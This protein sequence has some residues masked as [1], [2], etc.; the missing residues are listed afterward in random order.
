MKKKSQSGAIAIMVTLILLIILST[1]LLFLPE[2]KPKKKNPVPVATVTPTGAITPIPAETETLAV[3]LEV[4]T[5]VK[6]ITVYDVEAE[7]TKRLVYTG[8]TSFYDGYGIQLSAGQL[9]KGDMYR[10]YINVKEEWISNAYEAVDRR[11]KPQNTKVWEKTGVDYMTVSQG[12]ISFRGQNYRYNDGICV[13][14]NGRQITLGDIQPTVDI[15]T[16]RGVGQVIYEIDVTKGHGYITLKNHEDFIGGVIT[17]GSTRVDSVYEDATYLVREGTYTVSVECGKYAG[18]EDISVVRDATAVFDVF[19]YGSG[20]IKKGWL[21]I[22]ID[23]LGADLYID[24]V[25][26]AYTD[27]VELEYG[28]YRFEFSEGGYT[29]YNATVLIDQPK[30]SLSVFLIEQKPEET[31]PDDDD[32]TTTDPN[33]PD[34]GDDT[35]T[36]PEDPDNNTGE[37]NGDGAGENSDNTGEQTGNSSGDDPLSG[38]MTSVSVTG[39]GYNLDME[40]AIYILGPSGAEVYLDGEYLGTAPMDFEKILGSYVI[41]IIRSDGAVKNFNCSENDN[42]SDSYYNFSWID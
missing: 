1:V 35:G 41:T 30:Q 18:R 42:G 17:I 38:I 16:V 3:V 10:F 2:E 32:D 37:E 14:S 25:K 11:E 36:D 33:A 29:S 20:P 13:M 19:E 28:T 9:K 26:T 34:D 21:T 6:M 40:S 12:K 22:N 15:V 23:P 5:E 4:D 39:M 7:E 24:G 27:G 31:N 8:A